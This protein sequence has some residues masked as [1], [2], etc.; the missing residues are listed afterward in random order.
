MHCTLVF[1]VFCTNTEDDN[2]VRTVTEPDFEKS[3]WFQ[4]RD[5]TSFLG[6]FKLFV[7]PRKR[8]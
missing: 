6:F 4:E 3:N 2:I 5:K 1:S 8:L 7:F